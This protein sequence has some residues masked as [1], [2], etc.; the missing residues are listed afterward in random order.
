MTSVWFWDDPEHFINKQLIYSKQIGNKG[1]FYCTVRDYIRKPKGDQPMGLL[2][3]PEEVRSI[4]AK[5]DQILDVLSAQNDLLG[6]I[7][8]RDVEL[9]SFEAKLKELNLK[10]QHVTDSVTVIKDCVRF[11]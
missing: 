1:V 6:Q 8:T 2:P 4:H 9:K 7:V 11:K 5:I 10:M 3:V